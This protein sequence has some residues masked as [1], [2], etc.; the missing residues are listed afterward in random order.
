MTGLTAAKFRLA[1]R[2]TLKA[3]NHADITVFDAET[4][5]D[6]ADFQRSTEPAQGIETVIVAG[7]IV[8][9]EGRAT[10][11]RPGR[12]LRNRSGTVE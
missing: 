7:E 12:L 1:G 3:G 10:G 5:I 9:R 4:V 2:G 11:K 6:A 8:W